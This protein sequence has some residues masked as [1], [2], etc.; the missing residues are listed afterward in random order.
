MSF[1]LTMVGEAAC[2]LRVS[3]QISLLHS[4]SKTANSPINVGCRGGGCGVCKVQVLE[5]TY[6]HK[7][8]SK[9]HITNKEL[10]RGVVL[11]CRIIPTSDLTVLAI[12]ECK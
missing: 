1:V 5:G 12:G 6:K 3:G 4:V 7:P 2:E 11:A 9:A 10:A 8:M